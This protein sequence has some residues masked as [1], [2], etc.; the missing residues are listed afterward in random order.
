M[1]PARWFGPAIV[2]QEFGDFWIWIVGPVAGAVVAALVYNVF[3]MGNG[4]A[5]AA[6]SDGDRSVADSAGEQVAKASASRSRKRRR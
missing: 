4:T 1:N 3:L 5:I 2:Q 6:A